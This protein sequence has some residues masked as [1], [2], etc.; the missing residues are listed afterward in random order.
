MSRGEL[1]PRVRELAEQQGRDAAA[2]RNTR[3]YAPACPYDRASNSITEREL[4]AVWWDALL[5][6][7]TR[8]RVQPLP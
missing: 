7:S 3:G 6:N 5:D 2:F 1:G 8:G 4:A